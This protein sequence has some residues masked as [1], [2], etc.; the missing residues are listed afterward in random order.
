[1]Q[2]VLTNRELCRGDIFHN[3]CLVPC[4]RAELRTLNVSFL[5]IKNV[6]GYSRLQG[7]SGH[8]VFFWVS[9]K[10]LSLRSQVSLLRKVRTELLTETEVDMPRRVQKANG[11]RIQ[12]TDGLF[13]SKRNRALQSEIATA[14]AY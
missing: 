5:R 3:F 12:A 4:E 7:K 2:F 6:G 1:M 13:D 14:R 11:P 10:P 8:V 9:T